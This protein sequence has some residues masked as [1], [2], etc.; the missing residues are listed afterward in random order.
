[1]LVHNVSPPDWAVS[2]DYRHFLGLVTGKFKVE[3]L[4]LSSYAE[5][6]TW[7]KVKE[8]VSVDL[9]SHKA[10]ST[11]MGVHLHDLT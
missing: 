4:P 6:I 11:N 1:M 2:D 9:S 10:T 5:G 3:G 7:E 8:L